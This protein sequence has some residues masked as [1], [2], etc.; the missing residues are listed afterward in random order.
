[1]IYY[2]VCPKCGGDMHDSRDV[3]GSF[4]TCMSCGVLK[5]ATRDASELTSRIPASAGEPDL[6]VK[7]A[8]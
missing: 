1:M 4:I 3:Y 6:E 8:A 7:R 5:H 2:R